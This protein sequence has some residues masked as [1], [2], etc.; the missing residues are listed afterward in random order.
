[1]SMF[2]ERKHTPR[3]YNINFNYANEFIK[4]FAFYNF[5]C[6]YAERFHHEYIEM[7]VMTDAT[8]A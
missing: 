5:Y 2:A 8:Y 3:N 7:I 1:M 6:N 4:I